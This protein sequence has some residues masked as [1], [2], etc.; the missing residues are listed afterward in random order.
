VPPTE[1]RA[2]QGGPNYRHRALE[3]AI[4]SF[5]G[6]QKTEHIIARA[7]L[8]ERFLSGDTAPPDDE[9]PAAA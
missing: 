2:R 3:L 4:G 8:F 1:G 6:T 5:S 7:V 9:P